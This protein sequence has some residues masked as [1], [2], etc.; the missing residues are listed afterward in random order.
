MSEPTSTELIPLATAAAAPPL[1][2]PAVREVS[3]GLL[4][5]PNTGLALWWSASQAATLV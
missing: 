3:H 1:D 2:P 5:R 4:V